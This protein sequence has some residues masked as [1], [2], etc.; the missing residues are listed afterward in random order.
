MSTSRASI[1]VPLMR[2]ILGFLLLVS[3]IN[4]F[5]TFNQIYIMAPSERFNTARNTTMYIFS[6]FWDNGRL[7]SASAA[8]VVLF[9]ILAGLSLVQT[10]LYR[11]QD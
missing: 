1:T 7:G 3:T 4:A 8:A 5:Q 10:L 9:V 11:K 2:P 6:E